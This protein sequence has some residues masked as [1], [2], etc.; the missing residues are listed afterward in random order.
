MLNLP[1]KFVWLLI[2]A[3]ALVQTAAAATLTTS[4]A[5]RWRERTDAGVV[6]AAGDAIY[7]FLRDHRRGCRGG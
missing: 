3:L 5:I 4:Y 7:F 2:F 1:M 6:N